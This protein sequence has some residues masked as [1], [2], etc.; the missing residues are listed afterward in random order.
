MPPAFGRQI[1]LDVELRGRF[2]MKMRPQ[3]GGTGAAEDASG[4]QRRHCLGSEPPWG[5]RAAAPLA[6]S[7]SEP[8]SD[9]LLLL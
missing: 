2:V 4:N 8:P 5:M 1:A 3:K 7:A 6:A 9:P